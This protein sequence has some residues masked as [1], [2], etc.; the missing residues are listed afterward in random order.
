MT[1]ALLVLTAIGA[2][3]AAGAVAT[4]VVTARDGYRRTPTRRSA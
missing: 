2:L 3:S 1:A 4:V